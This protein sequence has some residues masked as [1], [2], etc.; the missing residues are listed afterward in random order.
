MTQEERKEQL[1]MEIADQLRTQ[2]FSIEFK[3]KNNPEGI[4]IIYEVTQE[5]MNELMTNSPLQI[6]AGKGNDYDKER[7]EISDRTE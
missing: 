6:N 1:I 3:V 2:P 7:E 4:K 5:E